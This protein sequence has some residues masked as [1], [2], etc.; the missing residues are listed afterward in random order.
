MA[1]F[2]ASVRSSAPTTAAFTLLTAAGSSGLL[3]APSGKSG[4]RNSDGCSKYE[5]QTPPT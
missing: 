1:R 3:E 5:F 4:E 2:A